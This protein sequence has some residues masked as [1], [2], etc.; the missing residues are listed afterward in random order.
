MGYDLKMENREAV[1]MENLSELRLPLLIQGRV[2]P[3]K[4]VAVF[5]QVSWISGIE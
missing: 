5:G 1:L 3:S 2:T 4:M